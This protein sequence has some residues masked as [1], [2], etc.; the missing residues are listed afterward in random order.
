MRAAHNRRAATHPNGDNDNNGPADAYLQLGKR[1]L[2]VF[3]EQEICS[4]P[5][6]TRRHN[7]LSP[8]LQ[9]RHDEVEA[10]R[11]LAHRIVASTLMQERDFRHLGCREPDE[12]QWKLLKRREDLSVWKHVPRHKPLDKSSSASCNV[13]CSGTLEGSMDDMLYGTHSKTRDEMHATAAYLHSSHMDCAVLNVLDR[14]STE[15]PFRQLALKW[16]VAEAFGDAR[17]V[18][19]RDWFN[20]ESTGTGVDVSGQRYGYFLA[21]HVDHAGCPPMPDHSDVI[22]GKMAMCCIYRQDAGSKVV[23]VYARGSIDLG[24]GLPAFITSSASCAMMFSMAVS[25]DSAAGKRLTKL[26]LLRLAE[27]AK[28]RDEGHTETEVQADFGRSHA[29]LTTSSV[30]DF[31][32]ASMVS[33]SMVSSSTYFAA[34]AKNRSPG[35]LQPPPP[36][37]VSRNPCH[38]CDKK[39]TTLTLVRPAYRQCGICRERACSKCNVKRKLFG[40]RGPV[41]VMCCKICI[42]QSKR[43]SIDPREPCPILP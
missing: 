8:T 5:L 25:M 35:P 12:K 41:T 6:P 24:G 37:R 17:L 38:V 18:N 4:A 19:H 9:L 40:R 20:I 34:D 43:L 3:E 42:L 29:G 21:H 14:G 22:R 23:H 7:A 36:S 33:S 31:L 1:H 15:D 16:S 28:E 27:R 2:T 32:S 13:R 30:R 11:N 10:F 39:P 26:A